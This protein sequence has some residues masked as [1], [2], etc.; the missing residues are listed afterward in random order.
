[1][2]N[3][4]KYTLKNKKRGKNMELK[5]LLREYESLK[6]DISNLWRSL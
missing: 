3:D 2:L 4:E 5:E 6:A 1:M